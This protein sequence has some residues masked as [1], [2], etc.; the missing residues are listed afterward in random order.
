MRPLPG[1]SPMPDRLREAMD[2]RLRWAPVFVMLSGASLLAAGCAP[3]PD[4]I[5]TDND[6]G[7]HVQLRTG[8]LFDVV[9]ADDHDETG[10]Q[11]REDHTPA[12]MER[13]GSLYQ[14][15]RT[16]PAGNGHGTNTERYNVVDVGTAVVALVESDNGGR[17]CRR[18]E[19]TVTV[20]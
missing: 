8:Q 12:V 6:N 20:T 9:L 3:V 13:L 7:G 5:A 15:Q 17:V 18:F 11:W 4:V 19:V 1:R 14:P 10:C 16:P 2:R